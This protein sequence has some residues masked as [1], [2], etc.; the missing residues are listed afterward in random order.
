[1]PESG[2]FK[3]AE[4]R[5][6]ILADLKLVADPRRA[7]PVEAAGCRPDERFRRGGWLSGMELAMYAYLDAVY[8]GRNQ[9]WRYL[10]ALAL[11]LGAWLILGSIPAVG[12]VIASGTADLDAL[13]PL[14]LF[15]VTMV[16]FV[17]LLLGL[18]L[19]VRGV[20]GRPLT[21]LITAE[22]R[23]NGKR[24]AQGALVWLG[25]A[26]GMA[27][28]EA[29]LYPGR[30]TWDFEPGP[31]LTF[32]G[33][34]VVLVPLQTSAEEL[35]FRGYL[36]QMAGLHW[37]HPLGLSLL[38][39]VVFMLPHL[40][41]PEVAVNF[42]LLALYYFAFGTFAAWVTLHDGGLELALGLHAAN[43]LF[44]ALGASYPDSALRTPALFRLDTL[45][46]VF[47]LLSSFV[48][49]GLFAALVFGVWRRP[50]PVA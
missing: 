43:N 31:F 34:V 26:F 30:Y 10:L 25:L 8:R 40:G 21:S 49:L 14:A 17:G 1:M 20:H 16:S 23:V 47:N 41:N 15:L 22:A 32:A 7:H 37:R 36:L 33:L 13:N 42:G 39:G 45:D 3:P 4:V 11:I 9:G 28:V 6:I 18:F 50:A 44:A 35:L 24:V 48:A 38:S 46:P 19:A 12:L 27:L 2:P 5:L 29:W